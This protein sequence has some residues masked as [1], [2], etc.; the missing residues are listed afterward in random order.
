MYNYHT[1]TYRCGHAI[2]EDIEY[3]QEAIKA[4]YKGIG[5]S[6][7]VMLPKLEK[8]Y[9]RAHYKEK[10]NYLSSIKELKQKFKDKIEIYTAFECEWDNHYQKY[11]QQLLNNKEV[12][13]LIFGNHNCYFK[14]NQEYFLKFISQKRFLNRCNNL[15]I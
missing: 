6:D 14:G 2:G 7:H 15:F 1:H 5:F 10:E 3:V 4:S 12:D 9:I 13:Y 8:I 11:Y